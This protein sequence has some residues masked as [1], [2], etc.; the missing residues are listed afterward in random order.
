MRAFLS[1]LIILPASVFQLVGAQADP[2]QGPCPIEPCREIID[3]SS[4]WNDAKGKNDTKGIFN[5][6]DNGVVAGSKVGNFFTSNQAA[7]TIQMCQCYGCDY[8]L[9]EFVKKNKLCS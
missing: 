6:V 5:C 4:C 9:K 7:N 2:D 1:L 3:S 8:L